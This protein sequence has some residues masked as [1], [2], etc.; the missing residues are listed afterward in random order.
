MQGSNLNHRQLALE[1]IGRAVFQL[2]K[3]G[4]AIEPRNIILILQLQGAQASS[5]QQKRVYLLARRVV[6]EDLR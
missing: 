4:Q 1:V 3:S 5:E 2:I 6:I